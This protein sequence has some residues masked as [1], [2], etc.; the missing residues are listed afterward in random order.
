MSLTISDQPQISQ[1]IDAD[2]K[3]HW[4]I[5]DP[6]TR[7]SLGCESEQEVRSWL[8]QYFSGQH[9]QS[10]DHFAPHQFLDRFR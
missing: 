8:E 9:I 5:Y 4:K 2:N 7:R 3:P 1:T 10:P 6:R